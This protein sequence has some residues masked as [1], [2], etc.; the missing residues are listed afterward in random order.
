MVVFLLLEQVLERAAVTTEDTLV[1]LGDYM[2]GW[3]ESAKL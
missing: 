1:F 3:S 2:D